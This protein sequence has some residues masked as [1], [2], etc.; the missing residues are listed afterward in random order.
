MIVLAFR[1]VVGSNDNDSEMEDTEGI[2]P[3]LKN[4][5]IIYL[6]KITINV[7]KL[8]EKLWLSEEDKIK[9]RP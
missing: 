7:W 3:P 4:E 6:E 2:I 5:G 1:F 8:V 9:D